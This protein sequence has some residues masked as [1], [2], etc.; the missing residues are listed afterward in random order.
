[1]DARS[2]EVSSSRPFQTGMSLKL[3]RY[4]TIVGALFVVLVVPLVSFIEWAGWRL[5]ATVPLSTIAREQQG[6]DRAVWLGAFK[7][8]AP[9][10]LERIKLVQPEV[11]L[12]G[13]SRCGQAR[14]Q[15]FRPYKTYNA[16]LTAWP[17]EHLVDFIDRATRVAKPRVVIVAL[18]YFLFGDFLAEAWRKERT[19]DFRQGLDS[20]RRKLHDVIDF[21]DRTN[22]NLDEFLISIKRDQFEPIDHN[23][24][25]GTEATRGQF[26]FRSDGS[27]FVAPAY[28]RIAPEQLARG[29]ENVTGAFPGGQHL[30]ER[31]FGYIDRLSQLASDRGFTVVGIQFPILKTAT[32][33]MDTSQSYWPYAGLWR[34]LRSEATA[35]RF[36]RVGIRFFDMSRD[37]LNADANNFFDPAHPTERGVLRTIIELLDRNEF[38]EV[39]PRIDR[40]ALEDDIQRNLKSGE[41]FDLYH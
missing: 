4:L 8:Y 2:E 33:F 25:L 17:L 37:P 22:W 31:Q 30:S 12:V 27:I 14:A 41:L 6:A 28:R 1:M 10:K 26:G 13:S 7:D 9:Y 16:C 23:R 15:M 34:D 5:G 32:D 29:V 21:A 18:D 38:R 39:F 11:L 36:A 20:H 3:G 19:M 24:L 35:E 40:A